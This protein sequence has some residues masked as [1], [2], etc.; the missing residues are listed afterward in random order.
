MGDVVRKVGRYVYTEG[1]KKDVINRGG[2]K[3]S[4]EEI[5]NFILA[6]P[7]VE[8]VCIVAMP[9]EVYGERAC[10]FVQPKAGQTI[11]F[12]ELIDFLA[13]KQIAKFKLPER[14]ELVDSFPLSPAGK[15]LR[16]ELRA[17]IE[18]KLAAE[19]AERTYKVAR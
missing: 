4:S 5:E 8:N 17:L 7:K 2:E 1:R 9:D 10:A 14:L 11:G 15:I 3:I 6:H 16:R 19:R 13:Q 12:H 18:R